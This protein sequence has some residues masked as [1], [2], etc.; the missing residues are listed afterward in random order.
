MLKSSQVLLAG[1]A[2]LASVAKWR[3][4][5]SLPIQPPGHDPGFATYLLKI[6]NILAYWALLYLLLENWR[7]TERKVLSLCKTFANL[8]PILFASDR[9]A[10]HVDWKKSLTG[11]R[12]GEDVLCLTLLLIWAGW[13]LPHWAGAVPPQ[14]RSVI[15]ALAQLGEAL[16][17]S[18]RRSVGGSCLIQTL[19]QRLQLQLDFSAILNSDPIDKFS[20]SSKYHRYPWYIPVLWDIAGI[21]LHCCRLYHGYTKY[22]FAYIFFVF[23][24]SL[25]LDS[26]GIVPYVV[27][28]GQGYPWFI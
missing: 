23:G 19:T 20:C 25:V 2:R 21:S 24:I 27:W 7:A 5:I 17:L 13:L 6:R 16:S 18:S 11:V 28:T 22:M 15:A 10:F 1:R 8:P 3:K 9:R 12:R 26:W 4:T 14:Q